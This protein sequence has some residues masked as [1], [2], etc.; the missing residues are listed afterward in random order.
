M[1]RG[2]RAQSRPGRQHGKMT[3][4]RTLRANERS[5]AYGIND[6]GTIVVQSDDR[7]VRWVNKHIEALDLLIRAHIGWRLTS[8]ASF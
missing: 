5:C 7:A 2:E 3:D 6:S 4:L 8:T 1:C